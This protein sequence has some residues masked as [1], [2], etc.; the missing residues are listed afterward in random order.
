MLFNT[1]SIHVATILLHMHIIYISVTSLDL[2]HPS[3]CYIEGHM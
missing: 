3:Q 1:N 2:T